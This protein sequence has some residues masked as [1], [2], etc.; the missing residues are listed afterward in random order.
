MG[1]HDWRVD[2]DHRSLRLASRSHIISSIV[3]TGRRSGSGDQA[4]TIGDENSYARGHGA[5]ILAE[6]AF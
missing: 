1:E 3:M 2:T 4:V 5:D 6:F